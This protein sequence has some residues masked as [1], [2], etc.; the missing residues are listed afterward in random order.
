MPEKS[1][2]DAV[3]WL[4]SCVNAPDEKRVAV[5]AMMNVRMMDFFH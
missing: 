5:A 3:P 1:G 4:G 2:M